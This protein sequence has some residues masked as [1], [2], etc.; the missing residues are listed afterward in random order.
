A[1]GLFK[2]M[3]ALWQAAR[4]LLAQTTWEQTQQL[5]GGA[6]LPPAGSSDP[7]WDIA[8]VRAK[9]VDARQRQQFLV[10]AMPAGQPMRSVLADDAA[11]DA[12]PEISDVS[13]E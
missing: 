5:L 6:P 11:K 9:Y 8:K 12:T 13:D 2:T 4:F 3:G 1:G 7:A 10:E